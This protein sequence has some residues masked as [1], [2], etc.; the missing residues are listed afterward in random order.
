MEQGP[1][2]R[3]PPTPPQALACSCMNQIVT[4]LVGFLVTNHGNQLQLRLVEG[5]GWAWMAPGFWCPPQG[6][7]V[8]PAPLPMPMGPVLPVF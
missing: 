8:L 7:S 3:P 6:P 4:G 2:A 1:Q 5:G